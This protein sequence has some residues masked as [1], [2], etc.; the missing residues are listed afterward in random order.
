MLLAQSIKQNIWPFIIE[1]MFK[2]IFPH[3]CVLL[4]V[5]FIF[6]VNIPALNEMTLNMSPIN[7][8]QKQKSYHRWEA[9]P[10][11]V[12]YPAYSINENQRNNDG[13]YNAKYY[14]YI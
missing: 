6:M 2:S 4:L 8:L 12:G 5:I 1:M 14:I 13:K 7:S 9:K 3:K 11:H 10:N